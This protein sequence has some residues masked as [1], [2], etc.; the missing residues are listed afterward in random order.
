MGSIGE[1]PST[2]GGLWQQAELWST[3]FGALRHIGD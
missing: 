1:I 3:K 2:H